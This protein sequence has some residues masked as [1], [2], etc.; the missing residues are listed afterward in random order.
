MGQLAHPPDTIA[1]EEEARRATKRG[2]ELPCRKPCRLVAK[3]VVT[4]KL[5]IPIRE[6]G[7]SC[8]PR[9]RAEGKRWADGTPRPPPAPSPGCDLPGCGPRGRSP[10]IRARPGFVSRTPRTARRDG[11]PVGDSTR[12]F[13]DVNP[14]ARKSFGI[15]VGPGGPT[16]PEGPREIISRGVCVWKRNRPLGSVARPG[17]SRR[18]GGGVNPAGGRTGRRDGVP[19]HPGPG[20]GGPVRAPRRARCDRHIRGGLMRRGEEKGVGRLLTADS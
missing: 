20:R 6:V 15:G 11:V 7:I 13:S 17:G 8:R 18:A 2:R 14:W 4:A 1:H 10:S 5:G 3:A 9:T 12:A 19:G 16:R